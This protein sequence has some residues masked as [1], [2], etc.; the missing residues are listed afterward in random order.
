[1]DVERF[2]VISGCSGGG[3]STLLMELAKRGHAVVD[4]PGRRIVREELIGDGSSLPWVDGAAFARRAIKLALADRAGASRFGGWVFFDRGLID[5]AAALQ[6]LTG[7]PALATLKQAHRYHKRVFITPPWR[8][9]YVNDPERRHGF[10]D[11]VLEHHRLMEVYPC[12]DYEVVVLPKAE[13]TE[14]ADF[15]MRALKT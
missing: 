3:K 10:D 8:E 7:E 13:P 4:E 2:V 5:A 11:A 9:I 12:L 6:H 15:V 14:R 1:M